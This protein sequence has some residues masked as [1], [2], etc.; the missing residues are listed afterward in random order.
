MPG[1][2]GLADH[3]DYEPL[4]SGEDKADRIILIQ[5]NFS[6]TGQCSSLQYDLKVIVPLLHNT[7]VGCLPKPKTLPSCALL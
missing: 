1:A 5:E 4:P 3:G 7:G 6:S 2:T